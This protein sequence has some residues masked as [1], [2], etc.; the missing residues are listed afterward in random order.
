[1]PAWWCWRATPPTPEASLEIGRRCSPT[2]R[3]RCGPTII[4]TFSESCCARN[5]AGSRLFQ[6][7]PRRRVIA[8]AFLAAHCAVDTGLAEAWRQ[9]RAQKEMIE[10]KPGVARPAVAL[11]VPERE[12]RLCRVPGAARIGPA[13]P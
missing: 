11:V 2:H 3:A 7:D 13:L 9:H 6:R 5:S 12:H 10:P 1:M 4:P 8:G